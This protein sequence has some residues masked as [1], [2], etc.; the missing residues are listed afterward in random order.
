MKN[1]NY[2]ID[3]AVMVLENSSVVERKKPGS[4]IDIDENSHIGRH[5]LKKR[6]E[7]GMFQKD[8]A[9]I[10]DVTAESIS[11]WEN[12]FSEPQI[13]FNPAI[14]SFLGYVPFSHPME[15]LAQRIKSYRMVNGISHE[16]MGNLLGVDS[17]TISGWE[18]EEHVPRKLT[19]KKFEALLSKPIIRSQCQ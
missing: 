6:L 1:E 10:I 4:S 14:I 15:T 16:R 7:L 5:M 17:S 2:I 12:G 11:N 18:T 8:V 13:Q 3:V 9:T 19:L